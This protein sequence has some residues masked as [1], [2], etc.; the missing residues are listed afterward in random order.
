MDYAYLGSTQVS[1]EILQR[2][3][4]E[5][6]LVLSFSEEK[7]E[8]TS[9]FATYEQ[10]DTWQQVETINGERARELLDKADPDII[11]V[12]AWQE[13]LDPETLAIPEHGCVGRHLSLLPKR[14]G[15]APVAWALIHGLERSGVSLFW[16]D[17]GVDTGD[18]VAQQEVEIGTEDEAHN[19]H[20]KMTDATVEL[21]EK[22]TPQFEAAAFPRRS[23]DDE[24]ATYTHPRRPDM[25][26]IDWSKSAPQL[27]DFVRGQTHPYPGAFTYY[28]MDRIRVWHASIRQRTNVIG[29]HGEVLSIGGPETYV[30]QTGEGTLEIEVE[31]ESD[32]H[33][34]EKGSVLGCHAD[35]VE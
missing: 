33:S 2:L 20:E 18:I 1:K 6:E 23:Q 32:A 4:I 7:R 14:R 29:R 21:L 25:G 17:E 8:Q 10:H 28:K 3:S 22:V 19:L 24:R 31:K 11:L 16:L 9:G 13:L 34:L 12:M 15:R 35:A 5:P 26:L 27:H 30:I